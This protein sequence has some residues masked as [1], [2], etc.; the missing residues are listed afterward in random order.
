MKYNIVDDKAK[1]VEMFPTVA[2]VFDVDFL[3]G[4]SNGRTELGE[5]EFC[6]KMEYGMLDPEAMFF[7]SHRKYI[8]IQITL[9]GLELFAVSNIS[10][11]S[12]ATD[13]DESSDLIKYSNKSKVEKLIASHPLNA[14]VFDINDGH[15]TGIG[16]LEQQVEKVVVKVLKENANI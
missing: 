14:V 5:G 2:K 1:L 6:M 16:E 13:Y 7:E 4:L 11:L 10:E 3:N 12:E 15:M 9:T 8:D